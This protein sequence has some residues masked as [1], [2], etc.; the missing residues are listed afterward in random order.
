MTDHNPKN[1]TVTSAK[2]KIK[3]MKV[4]SNLYKGEG[5][6]P[7]RALVNGTCL[8]VGKSAKSL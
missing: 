1:N 6:L 2:I 3:I 8:T 5:Y 4:I 7:I